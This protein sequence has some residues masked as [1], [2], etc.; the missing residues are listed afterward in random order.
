MTG[1]GKHH[2]AII[3]DQKLQ[4]RSS[5]KHGQLK[6]IEPETWWKLMTVLFEVTE[7]E[8]NNPPVRVKTQ[9]KP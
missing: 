1:W 5:H 9:T 2:R 4:I 7:I 3:I 8:V 6:K